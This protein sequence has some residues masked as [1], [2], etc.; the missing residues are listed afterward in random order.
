MF[1]A[2]WNKIYK[3]S[4]LDANGIRF[5]AGYW[6]GEGMLFNITCLQYVDK[7]AVGE[8]K[9]YHQEYNPDSAMRS[10]NLKSNYCGIRSL[11]RQKELWLKRNKKIEDAWNYHYR[12]FSYSILFGFVQTNTVKG[13]KEEYKRCIKNLRTNITVPLK[14][15]IGFK[16]KLVQMLVACCPVLVAKRA[17]KK[18][19]KIA[20]QT[21]AQWGK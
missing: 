21:R 14:V 4:F 2:V 19:A 9:V 10:F 7:I 8:K 1:V 20:K 16:N 17:A 3:K 6:Y 11:Y 13:N 18:S 12:C 5:D 15:D